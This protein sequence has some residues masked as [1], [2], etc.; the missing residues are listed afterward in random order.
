MLK[1]FKCYYFHFC[2]MVELNVKIGGKKYNLRESNNEF[3]ILNATPTD[4]NK[5]EKKTNVLGVSNL[6]RVNIVRS[7]DSANRDDIMED[8][9]KTGVAHHVY[10]IENPVKTDKLV[11]TD[12]VNLKFK[13]NVSKENRERFMDKYHLQFR[14]R[15]SS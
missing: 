5:L 7:I 9:R 15:V 12:K 13:P 3:S 11:I 14:K 10:E 8:V 1:K 6:G 4:V 2:K